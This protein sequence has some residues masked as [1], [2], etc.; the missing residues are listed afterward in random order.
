MI[1]PIARILV[2]YIAGYLALRAIMPQ[3]VADMIANDPDVAAVVGFVL[4]ALVEGVYGL[5]KHHG[6][7]T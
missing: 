5:A 4:M 2:R 3:S 7:R 6:W 1:G